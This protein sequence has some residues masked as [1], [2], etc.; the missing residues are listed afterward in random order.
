[1]D[2]TANIK[3]RKSAKLGNI[4]ARRIRKDIRT[5]RG[6][7][8]AIAG[9]VL[10]VV[11]DMFSEMGETLRDPDYGKNVAAVGEAIVPFL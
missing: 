7:G 2:Q 5:A 4:A 8:Q 11:D 1:L 9:Q 10:G 3:D 6:Q